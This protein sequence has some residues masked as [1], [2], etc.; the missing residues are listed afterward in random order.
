MSTKS[1]FEIATNI[2]YKLEELK[3]TEKMEK[4]QLVCKDF[5]SKIAFLV[6]RDSRSQN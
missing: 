2:D 3:D 1:T 6:D 5:E 4:F